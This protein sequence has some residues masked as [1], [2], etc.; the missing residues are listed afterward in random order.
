MNHNEL[1]KQIYN[2]IGGK[3]NMIRLEHC[4]T[5]LRFNLK[6][7]TLAQ[8]KQIEQLE[9]VV[10]VINKGG[11]Y[12]VVIGT[13]VVE[14]FQAF[15]KLGNFET[16]SQEPEE[17][18]S[19]INRILDTI[20]GIFFPIVPALAGAGMLKALLS[21]LSVTNMVVPTSQSYQMLNFMGDA[22]FY[23]LPIIV[24]AS[25][26]K[27]LNVNMYVAMAIGAMLLHPT[28]ISMAAGAKET[29]TSI[30]LFGL[31]I[32]PVSYTSSVIPIILAIWFMSYLEPIV[33][34][35]MF[36][37]IRLF[38]TPLLSMLLVGIASFV[39]L[40]P[41][42]YYLG[43]ALGAGID[44][45]NQFASWIVPLLVG[46][47]TPLMV[48]TGMHYG[49]IPLGI[50]QLAI[51]GIDTIAGPGMLVSNIAQGGASLA[52]AFKTKNT[53]LKSLASS[54]GISAVCGITEPAMYGI[55]LRYK[56]PLIA[57]M[58]GGG[59]GGLFLGVMQVGR[60]AQV[61]PGIFALPSFI[62]STGM[63]NFFYACI[64]SVIAFCTAF[65]IS[66]L[67]GVD[68]TPED[69]KME[70]EISTVINNEILFA[71]LQGKSIPLTQVNDPLFSNGTMGKGA[72]IIPSD[73][74]LYA[75]IDGTIRMVF[76]T[77]HAIGM[78]SEQGSEIL[79]HVGMDTVELKGAHFHPKVTC[80]MHVK[81]GDVLLEF[82][83]EAITKLGYD[84][85]TPMIITNA[86]PSTN[87]QI[88]TQGSIEPG[89]E[90]FVISS[91]KREV[92]K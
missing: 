39:V 69:K 56:K 10:S 11:Q 58:I 75:P 36:K 82:D 31:P 77:G 80:D 5:R 17:N 78:I 49:L 68:E 14:V 76:E 87:L 72:A 20:S 4:A 7:D 59:L 84:C 35:Y 63:N 79:I 18:K 66:Y 23:F 6:D 46:A 91:E 42:G 12:Q 90:F 54:A 48:M 27:K 9:G 50:N 2:Y 37:P 34:R 30:H 61:A 16:N 53:N 92:I 85:T 86:N 3:E 24:A 57:A 60:Y 45:I 21:L 83:L 19:L 65:L 28:F 67:L 55:S 1:A 51:S 22:L 25:A 8:T 81:K 43:A 52:V 38:M 71:P 29:A 13:E 32:A 88:I 41:L 73:G 26:A 74:K 47:F 89:N 64:G 33:D 44:F 15:M 40:G 62:G 70:K